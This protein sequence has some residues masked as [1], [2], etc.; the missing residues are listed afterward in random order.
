MG[1][2]MGRRCDGWMRSPPGA[3]GTGSGRARV[4]ESPAGVEPT[5]PF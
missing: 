1:G 3:A 2:F 5:G 4:R